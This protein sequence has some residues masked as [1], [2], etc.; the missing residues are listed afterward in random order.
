MKTHENDSDLSPDDPDDETNTQEG[1]HPDYPKMFCTLSPTRSENVQS[2]KE[3]VQI[4]LCSQ[5]NHN[6]W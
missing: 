4:Q 5:E 6:P 1:E 2:S 3:I